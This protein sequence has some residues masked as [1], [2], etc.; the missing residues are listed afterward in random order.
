MVSTGSMPQVCPPLDISVTKK[1]EN[2][3][4][5]RRMTNSKGKE[6][7][8]ATERERIFMVFLI[9]KSVCVY[10]FL[11]HVGWR[12]HWTIPLERR[13]GERWHSRFSGGNFPFTAQEALRQVI[14]SQLRTY[15]CSIESLSS[16]ED[17]HV[18][19]GID[20]SHEYRVGLSS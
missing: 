11:F 5:S 13:F 10:L 8:I 3:E 15:P 9:C 6:G 16:T 4:R 7:L 18:N 2:E 12:I 20:D 19:T 1:E 17:L 14:D